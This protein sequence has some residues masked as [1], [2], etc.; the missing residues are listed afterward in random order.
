MFH[1]RCRLEF[2]FSRLLTLFSDFCGSPAIAIIFCDG[3]VAATAAL[4][5][6]LWHVR[7]SVV[8]TVPLCAGP[9]ACF[10]VAHFRFILTGS[11]FRLFFSFCEA[12]L[13]GKQKPTKTFFLQHQ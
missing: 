13:Y 4:F 6:D 5:A 3:A 8:V 12:T 9:A 11:L 2:S 1:L 7:S 10:C